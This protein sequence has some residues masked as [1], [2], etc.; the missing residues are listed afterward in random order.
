[1]STR[2]L[3]FFPHNL[4]VARTGAHQRG[5][6]VL[7]ALSGNGCDVT[8]F[9]STASTDVSWGDAQ[10]G[11]L[12]HSQCR[13]LVLHRPPLL[14]AAFFRAAK[15]GHRAIKSR[16]PALGSNIEA[17]AMG[18][19]GH[20]TPSMRRAFREQ[21]DRIDPQI[22]L[23]NYAWWDGLIDHGR[24]Q[25]RLRIIDT[26]DLVSVA[27]RLSATIE[28]LIPQGRL[29]PEELP[30][31]L[32]R[33]DFF[34]ELGTSDERLQLECDIYDQ[35]DVA[36]AISKAE[37][38]IIESRTA[39]TKVV[40]LPMTR[41]PVPLDNDYSG[42]ALFAAG[43]NAFNLHGYA[44]FLAKVMPAIAH[45]CP[46]FEMQVTG[47]VCARLEARPGV[48]IRG[49]V[50]NLS[51]V[52]ARAPFLVNP[53]FGGTGQQIKI[54]DAMAHGIPVI[55]LERAAVASPIVHGENG[56]IA[57]DAQEFA[58]YAGMLWRDRAMCRRLGHRARERIAD[59]C[60]PQRLSAAIGLLVDQAP[61]SP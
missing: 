42:A 33:E 3:A 45:F 44:Y 36:I 21:I 61:K 26:H 50:Q 15:A 29:R 8:L 43:M 20:A 24:E 49:M 32:F 6:E 38:G 53:V 37:G 35:Y 34:D 55:A 12:D 41:A 59:E 52:Y 47:A 60:S 11:I 27:V 23:M 9:S 48:I 14:E 51:D 31:Y 25:R 19:A 39:R 5:L 4:F 40:T 46:D 28:G 30:E 54:V 17:R 13:E 22:L 2:V 18:S 7:A 56:L 57:H 16:L 10:T 58:E 1:M